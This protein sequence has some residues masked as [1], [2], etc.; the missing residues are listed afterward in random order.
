MSDL[1]KSLEEVVLKLDRL[2]DR[3]DNLQMEIWRAQRGRIGDP[4]LEYQTFILIITIKIDHDECHI[5][6]N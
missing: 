2:R 5:F 3:Y 1:T 6:N 4:I